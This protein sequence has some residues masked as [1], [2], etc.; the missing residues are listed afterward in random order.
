MGLYVVK[1]VRN[2]GSPLPSYSPILDEE[3]SLKL[4]NIL[5]TIK[6]I[7]I[8]ENYSMKSGKDKIYFTVAFPSLVVFVYL[9]HQTIGLWKAQIV[10]CVQIVELQFLQ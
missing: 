4:E 5:K 10:N 6:N 9:G 3:Y 1:R 7:S 2:R 8:S